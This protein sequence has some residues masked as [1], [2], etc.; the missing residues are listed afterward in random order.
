MSRP[1]ATLA[2]ACWVARSRGRRP[3]PS[4]AKPAAIAPEETKMIWLPALRRS[5]RTS[6]RDNSAS[7]EIPPASEVSED[8]P[9]LTT[10]RLAAG[11]S[12]RSA[13]TG[14]VAATGPRTWAVPTA[15][16]AVP[17]RP[18]SVVIV[19]AGL[20]LIGLGP[21]ARLALGL[22]FG[23][24]CS[25]G[26]L[27]LLVFL[28]LLGAGG[29]DEFLQPQVGAAGRGEQLGAAHHGRL[30]VEDH[31]ILP[32]DDYRVPGLGAGL[33]QAVFDPELGQAVG[34]EAHGL[35]IVE[36]RLLDPALRL[37]PD[38]AEERLQ[39]LFLAPDG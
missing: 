34:Q 32:A 36:V 39:V 25:P 14:F 13:R 35:V 33:E 7:S 8:E 12:P 20:L 23:A 5:A 3:R 24:R 29:P 21:D 31:A 17:G 38:D 26:V 2:A 9:T 30:P 4:G 18:A 1:S 22:E 16:C 15:S 28:A 37:V 19:I 10:R 6:T 27:A 11:S